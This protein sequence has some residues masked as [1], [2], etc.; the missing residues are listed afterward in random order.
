MSFIANLCSNKLQEDTQSD[1]QEP[2]K[3]SGC[4]GKKNAVVIV[5][6]DYSNPEAQT[7]GEKFDGWKDAHETTWKVIKVVGIA[8]LVLAVLAAITTGVVFRVGPE[9][10]V[11]WAQN[12]AWP[13]IQEHATALEFAAAAVGGVLLGGAIAKGAQIV[14]RKRLERKQY[15]DEDTAKLLLTENENSKLGGCCGK[16][17]KNQGYAPI[18]ENNPDWTNVG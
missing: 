10:F 3:T 17:N 7:L 1:Y 13:W 14:Y 2:K 9:N 11:N 12:T 16:S 4:F 18:E 6:P 15:E 5:V 8:L